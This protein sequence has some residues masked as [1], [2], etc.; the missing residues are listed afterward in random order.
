[1]KVPAAQSAHI[2]ASL[3]P[4]ALACLCRLAARYVWWKS[5]EEAMQF[6]DRIAAQVMNMGDWNDMV[7]LVNT[8]G[9]NYLRHVLRHAEAG[10]LNERSWHYWHYRLGLAEFGVR[11]VPPMPKRKTA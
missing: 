2:D 7:D 1:M 11:P 5:P 10:Q 6:P 4:P 8:A 9:E 3:T